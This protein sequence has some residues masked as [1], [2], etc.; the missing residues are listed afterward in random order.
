MRELRH[1]LQAYRHEHPHPRVTMEDLERWE[2]APHRGFP[3]FENARGHRLRR[4]GGQWHLRVA[5]G[6]C[7]NLTL[8]GALDRLWA[9]E[10]NG[11]LR[12]RQPYPLHP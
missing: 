10:R 12:M 9:G 11:D 1:T 8:R 7:L 5:T 3:S 4:G 2:R 6:K